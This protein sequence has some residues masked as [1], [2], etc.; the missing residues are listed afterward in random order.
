MNHVCL[1]IVYLLCTNIGRHNYISKYAC[2]KTKGCILT[3]SCLFCLLPNY[4]AVT[5][6]RRND[7]LTIYKASI[8]FAKS[9]Q[10]RKQELQ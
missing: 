5:A 6:K 4:G 1:D 9:F 3:K 2:S 7:N 10:N 8:K